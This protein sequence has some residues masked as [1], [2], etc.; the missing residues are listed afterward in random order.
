MYLIGPI[1]WGYTSIDKKILF[2]LVVQIISANWLA[3][4]G[5]TLLWGLIVLYAE[6]KKYLINQT[7]SIVNTGNESS[8][9]STTFQFYAWFYWL[10]GHDELIKFFR[11]VWYIL[12]TTIFLVTTIVTISVCSSGI[13][14]TS[15][16][17]C[18]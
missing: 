5:S 4:I 11:F 15:S 3:G 8:V 9:A 6:P 7:F 18:H 14:N 1:P 17:I 2:G 16:F 10:M 12:G 13:H